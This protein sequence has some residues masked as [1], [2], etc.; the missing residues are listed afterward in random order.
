MEYQHPGSEYY[1]KKNFVGISFPE[2]VK[3]KAPRKY[4]T[5]EQIQKWNFHQHLINNL[6]KDNICK[7]CL[8]TTKGKSQNSRFEDFNLLKVGLVISARGKKAKVLFPKKKTFSRLSKS[9]LY[10]LPEH[11]KLISW[12]NKLTNKAIKLSQKPKL[13]YNLRNK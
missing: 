5:L 2:G 11:R 9:K 13:T 8:V 3:K 12:N 7:D 4:P 1:S 6:T 10:K